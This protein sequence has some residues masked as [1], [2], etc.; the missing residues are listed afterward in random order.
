MNRTKSLVLELLAAV[1]LVDGG[2]SIVLRAFD[3]FKDIYKETS[4]FETLMNYFRKDS[5]EPD[6]NIDFMVIKIFIFIY[7][8]L[9]SL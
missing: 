6:F 3:N 4:R 9:V 2:H 5:N 1:C 8:K 7:S